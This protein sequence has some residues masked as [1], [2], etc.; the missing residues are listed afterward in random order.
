MAEY[1]YV[2]VG[3]G[4]AGCVLAN[5][6]SADPAVSVALVEVGGRDRHPYIHM[7][8]GIGKMIAMPS[9]MWHYLVK[10]TPHNRTQPDIWLRGK[11]LGGSSSVNGM[12]WVKGQPADYEELAD[13]AG[14]YWGWNSFARAFEAIEA[15]EL[16]AAPSRGG[17]G[18]VK[19]TIPAVRS[20]LT[21]AM[22]AAGEKVG[23]PIKED[24]NEPDSGEGIGLMPC[25]IWR[26]KR[27]SA[28]VAFLRPVEN[29]P[30]LTVVTGAL[31]EKVLFGGE[32]ATGIRVIENGK[33][34]DISARREVILSAGAVASPGILERSGIG[35]PAVLDALGIEPV[36]AAPGVGNN[37]GEHRAL[38][39]QW[40]LKRPLS[41]NRE[42]GG[43]KLLWNVLRYY[44]TH[45]GPMT[46][47]AIEMRAAFRSSPERNRADIQTQIG[48][49]SWDLESDSGA[50][51]KEHGFCA[52]SYPVA[53]ASEG[54]IHI[55]SPDPQ[56][57]PA[58]DAGY[59]NVEEDR[60][61]T[62]LAA[63][64]LREW[65]ATEPLASLIERETVPGP[66]AQS[67]E[68]IL[69]CMDVYGTAGLH[70]VGSCRMGKDEASV[71]DPSL[72]VRGVEG[73]RVIDAS[74][75]PVIPS[76]NT[77]APVMALAWLAAEMIEAGG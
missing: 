33:E 40:R 8:K 74:V 7:P 73:L 76:G 59:G 19:V 63:R 5:R 72:R 52:L 75:F 9:L 58:I 15:H 48:L 23:W 6:L 12:V 50:L 67:D 14:E 18:P 27:Q 44:L 77:N 68:A 17:S 66:E 55:V 39:M 57:P 54:S 36:H 47:A 51:E 71:V 42:F 32:R 60:Q 25:S 4:S 45:K 69:E 34:R 70:T 43:P 37:V 64:R 65:A 30:N 28:A 11:V 24:V 29:R 2:I 3:G 62:V 26:G 10:S 1:D 46:G 53:P 56:V 49:F 13:R 22:M 31:T 38:R 20:A 16:G 21:D 35:D 41:L 61:R